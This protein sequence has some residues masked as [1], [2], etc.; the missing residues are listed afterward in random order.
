[1]IVASPMVSRSVHTGTARGKITTPRPIFAPSALRY[2]RYSGD[3]ANMASGL[4]RISVFTAQNRTYARL[5]IR[6][7]CGRH[8]PISTHFA[9]IGTVLNPRKVAATN[10]AER[11]YT[12]I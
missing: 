5:Q 4:D 1:M 11:R 6:I 8:R 9:T 2:S 12:V 3:P 10:A 7:S